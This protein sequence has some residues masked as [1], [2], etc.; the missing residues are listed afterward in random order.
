MSMER[1]LRIA[2]LV[3]QSII[4]ITAP[5][6]V[7]RTDAG[8]SV[9]NL[10]FVIGPWQAFSALMH[11]I[12]SAKTKSPSLR[13]SYNQLLIAVV[14]GT[15]LFLLIPPVLLYWLMVMIPVGAL[16]CIFYL[17]LTIYEL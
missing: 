1:I 5:F 15:I 3:I 10:F 12:F 16:M 14:L 9:I 13:K 8:T 6:W 11:W 7:N 2:D 17:V 4:I